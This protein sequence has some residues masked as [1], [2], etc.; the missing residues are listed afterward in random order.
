MNYDPDTGMFVWRVSQAKRIKKWSVAGSINKDGYIKISIDGSSYLAHRLAWLYMRG[1]FP[2]HS[3]DHINHNRLDNRFSNLREADY[4]MNNK[5]ASKIKDNS[6][7]VTGV[8]WCNRDKKWLARITVDKKVII[9]GAFVLFSDALDA[10]KNAE[11]LYG[12]HE[13]HG[14]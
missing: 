13:N 10:R 6:S 2:V 4:S 7:G 12:F 5:N 8:R 1:R 9:L 14:K 11:A 3:I